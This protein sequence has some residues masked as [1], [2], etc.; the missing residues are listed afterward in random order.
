[1]PQKSSRNAESAHGSILDEC[2]AGGRLRDVR[3]N[4]A[5]CLSNV[6]LG[7]RVLTH[8]QF[9]AYQA[10]CMRACVCVCTGRGLQNSNCRVIA[11]AA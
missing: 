6:S 5:Q 8:V 4:I 9:P 1:M 11:G 3:R 7:R 10:L 2:R